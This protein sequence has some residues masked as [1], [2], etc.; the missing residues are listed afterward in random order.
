MKKAGT[1]KRKP[2]GSNPL[3]VNNL[4]KI[5]KGIGRW[6][7]RKNWSENFFTFALQ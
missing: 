6:I 1:V 4:N 3:P 5:M 2:T 7:A